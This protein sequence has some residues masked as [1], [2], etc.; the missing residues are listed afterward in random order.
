M[1]ARGIVTK[2]ETI[3]MCCLRT[4]KVNFT[5]VTI[6]SSLFFR[7][8]DEEGN[9]HQEYEDIKKNSDLILKYLGL[10]DVLGTPEYE[11]LVNVS[12]VFVCICGRQCWQAITHTRAH[13]RM[14]NI[15]KMVC[16]EKSGKKK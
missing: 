6:Y 3:P 7:K 15:F 12:F 16:L 4:P 8:E 5:Y 10:I 2:N 13:T 1:G 14:H 9:Y 11:G